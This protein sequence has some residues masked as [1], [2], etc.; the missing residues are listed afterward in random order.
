MKNRE[1][2]V[3]ASPLLP[4]RSNPD[5]VPLTLSRILSWLENCN[6]GI[7]FLQALTD[8]ARVLLSAKLRRPTRST[9]NS[10]GPA[11]FESSP[12]TERSYVSTS[13]GSP[14]GLGLGLG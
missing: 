7:R 4:H 13:S 2:A 1:E 5:P 6:P 14:V 8:Q 11:L 9:R 10:R 12:T 3:S